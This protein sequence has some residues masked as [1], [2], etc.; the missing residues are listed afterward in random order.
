[1]FHIK[2]FCSD[3]RSIARAASA[4]KNSNQN[5]RQQHQAYEIGKFFI[6]ISFCCSALWI[7]FGWVLIKKIYKRQHQIPFSIPFVREESKWIY[8]FIK[9][10]SVVGRGKMYCSFA[11]HG[12]VSIDRHERCIHVINMKIHSDATR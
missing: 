5:T 6:L 8:V 10:I 1:M 11:H 9:A 4:E 2:S 12:K 7:I 3:C